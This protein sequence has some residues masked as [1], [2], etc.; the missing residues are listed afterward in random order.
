MWVY[1][2]PG[3]GTT[4]KIYLPRVQEKG[5]PLAPI[6]LLQVSPRGCETLLLVEDEAAVRESAR[7]FLVLCGYIVL[8]AQDGQAALRLARD[9]H[10]RIDLVVSDVVMPRMG[11]PNLAKELAVDRPETQVLFVSGYA[12]NTV[13]R[14]GAIDVVSRFLQKPFSLKALGRKI[15]EVLDSKVPLER[16]AASTTG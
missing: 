15:R 10:G 16:L 11:G 6:E 5:K 7:E 2:E 9:Y 1:S 13:L 14:H 12:E 3:L 4:F 8:E